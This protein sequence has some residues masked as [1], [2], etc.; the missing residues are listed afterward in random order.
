[1]IK[2]EKIRK[3][4]R[5]FAIVLI[6]VALYM[7]GQET[8][9]TLS[10]QR[11]Q[12]LLN[13]I[14]ETVTEQVVDTTVPGS[15]PTKPED[16]MGTLAYYNKL[17]AANAAYVGWIYMPAMHI[18]HPIVLAPNNSYYLNHSFYKS[19][20]MYGTLFVDSRDTKTFDEPHL[21]IYGHH[22]VNNSMFSYLD[23][24]RKEKNYA[25]NSTFQ[26]FTETGPKTYIIFA[27]ETVNADK[28]VLSL[29]YTGN[30]QALIRTYEKNALYKTGVDTS[31]A[32]Q[33]VTLVTC[34]V[35]AA[36]FRIL[37]HAIPLIV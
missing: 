24:L 20:N 9:S 21:V 10:H 37:I 34:T 3:S 14:K 27:V 13:Q 36:N 5:I 15:S 31:Q 35:V 2:N 25:A 1:M 33:V 11:E 12:K 17:K 23:Q 4:I 7:F 16:I 6:V 8:L 30:I 19:Y 29:P 32:T 22:M 28:T 18:D 26:I